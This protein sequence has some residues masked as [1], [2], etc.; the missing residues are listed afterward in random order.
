MLSVKQFVNNAFNSNT[1]LIQHKEV[2]PSIWLVDAGEFQSW[3]NILD[4]KYTISGVFLTHAH[5]DHILHLDDVIKNFPDCVIYC[6]TDTK[7]ALENPKL[8]LSFYHDHPIELHHQN[9]IILKEGDSIE[10]YYNFSLKVIETP[11][12]NKGSLSFLLQ[13]YFFTGDSLVPGFPVVTKLKGGDKE[14]NKQS[15]LKIQQLIDKETIICSGH[16]LMVP[17]NRV[18]IK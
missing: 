13:P 7:M 5:F 1:Y 8:N 16:G 10:L 15:L 4:S 2:S 12:H 9:I 11:G 17:G 18:E 6:S 14:Q 3:A